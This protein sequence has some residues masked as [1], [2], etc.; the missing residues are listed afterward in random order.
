MNMH[1]GFMIKKLAEAV[2]LAPLLPYTL[3]LCG[4]FPVRTLGRICAWCGLLILIFFSTPIAVEWFAGRLE[5]FPPVSEA[6]LK[7]VQAIVILGGGARGF[8]REYGATV[9]NQTTEERLR[10]GARLAR[11]T[12][13]PVLVSG[14]SFDG[15]EPEA[16]LMAESLREDYGINVQWCETQSLDTTDNAYFSSG[17]LKNAGIGKIILVTSALHMPRSVFEFR[18]QGLSVVAAPTSY[19]SDTTGK[20]MI[21]DYLP[22]AEGAFLGWSVIHEGVGVFVQWFRMALSF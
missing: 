7:T 1:T 17:I 14:G 15:T 9:P 18:H 12:G 10:Y 4:L 3:I 22:S 6:E 16:R 2:F 11:T 13:L 21:F 20:R 5:V 8:A 19:I